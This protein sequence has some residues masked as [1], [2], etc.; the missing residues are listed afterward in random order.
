M[1]Q[2]EEMMD[3]KDLQR[4][5]LNITQIALVT[6]RDTKTVRKYLAQK[7]PPKYTARPPVASKLDPFKPYIRMRMEAGMTNGVKM[8]TEIQKKGYTGGI[9]I[10]KDFMRPLRIDKETAIKRFETNPGFQAQVDWGHCGRIFHKG[11]VR[12]LYCFVM[13]LGFSRYMYV[14]FTARQDT[15]TFMRCHTNAF[16]FFGGVTEQILYDNTKS[17]VIRR[18]LEKVELNPRFADMA[19]HYGFTPRFCKPYRAQTK[20]KVESAIKYVKGNFLLGEVFSS[21]E[22]INAAA[23]AWLAEVANVHVH[24]TTGE[25]PRARFAKEGLI[26]IASVVPFDTAEHTYRRATLDSIISYRGARYSL[27][28]VATKRVVLIKENADGMIHIFLD[29]ESIYC[30]RR[31]KKGETVIVPDH[32]QG[33]AVGE[34]AQ[35][36]RMTIHGLDAPKVEVRDLKVYEEAL[37]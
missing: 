34:P 8:L 18:F 22:E 27:P 31:A 1:V 12:P 32:Y 25:V 13:T 5:G 7:E 30:H 24:G 4:Q 37:S 21:L 15:T 26:P 11:V 28:H 2:G 17:A 6:G 33:I 35:P 29:G 16:E 10:L 3:I 9:S 20:G 23:L 36:K 19:A 14:E